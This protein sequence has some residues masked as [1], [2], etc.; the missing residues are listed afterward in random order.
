MKSFLPQHVGG[1]AVRFT[2]IELL[3]VIA[4]IA[5]LAAILL[6]A[7]QSA[8]E[9]GRAT[10]CSN[11][12]KQIV[13]SMVNYSNDYQYFPPGWTYDE[14]DS[15]ND[16][17]WLLI[18]L[19][20]IPSGSSYLCPSVVGREKGSYR[21]MQVLGMTADKFE[22]S[23]Y[24]W[25][26][27]VGSYAYNIMGVGDDFYGNSP[28]YPIKYSKVSLSAPRALK[29]GKTKNPSKLMAT[30]EMK[31]M[32]STLMTIPSSTMDGEEEQLDPRHSKRF[33]ASF[34]DGSAKSM[35]V[36]TDMTYA[37]NNKL[38]DKFFRTYGYRDYVE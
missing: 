25:Y 26:A 37:R 9:R 22:K 10:S 31:Y 23:D 36:P 14:Q 2:L 34:V 12:A 1:K 38:H 35:T 32:S 3:V 27:R 30:S 5:I 29:P 19:K 18:G 4:I 33:N 28:T 15:Q 20:Y 6:P 13:L 7:L 16:Y 11:N 24:L 8:R 17:Q 21:A